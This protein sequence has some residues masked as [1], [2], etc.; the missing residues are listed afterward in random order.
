MGVDMAV[1][2]PA[3]RVAC[4]FD[5]DWHGDQLSVAYSALGDDVCGEMTDVVQCAAQYRRLAYN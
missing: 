3:M 4:R 5:L 2:T 1:T